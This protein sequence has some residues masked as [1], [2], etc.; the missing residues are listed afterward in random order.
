[1]LASVCLRLVVVTDVHRVNLDMLGGECYF[2]FLFLFGR[3]QESLLTGKSSSRPQYQR[4]VGQSAMQTS[5]GLAIFRERS[6]KGLSLQ[7]LS[8]I[9]GRLLKNVPHG[10]IHLTQS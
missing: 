1:M 5:F 8:R 6:P 7:P 9:P 3:S 10:R 4:A 2:F